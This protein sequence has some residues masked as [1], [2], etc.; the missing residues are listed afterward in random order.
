MWEQLPDNTL[1][2]STGVLINHQLFVVGGCDAEGNSM[3]DVYRY[4]SVNGSWEKIGLLNIPRLQCHAVCLPGDD[5]MV[6]GGCEML[7]GPLTNAVEI[8]TI[9]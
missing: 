8:S 9:L 1:F 3:G 6:V 7:N 5:L 4:D 2:Y